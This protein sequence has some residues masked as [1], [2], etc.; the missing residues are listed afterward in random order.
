MSEGNEPRAKHKNTMN[1]IESKHDLHGERRD[2][3]KDLCD[4]A[5][6][7]LV[8][9]S[10][11]SAEVR[12]ADPDLTVVRYNPERERAESVV[13]THK[14]GSVI[15]TTVCDITF[16]ILTSPHLD[17]DAETRA[18][19]IRNLRALARSA[20]RHASLAAYKAELRKASK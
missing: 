5:G 9:F 18:R 1:N 6:L 10:E 14:S 2:L 4:Q 20:R 11:Y 3:L 19:V 17:E 13:R 7:K 12:K 16:T 15:H 8:D